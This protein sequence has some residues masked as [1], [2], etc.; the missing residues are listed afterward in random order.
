MNPKSICRGS[1]IHNLYYDIRSSILVS[2]HFSVYK[3]VSHNLCNNR[4]N[5]RDIFFQDISN[6]YS[7][8]REY[9]CNDNL[10]FPALLEVALLAQVVLELSCNVFDREVDLVLDYRN[11]SNSIF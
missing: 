11:V 8:L 7:H 1:K 2:L 6:L 10:F 3:Q 9:L 5:V 4:I